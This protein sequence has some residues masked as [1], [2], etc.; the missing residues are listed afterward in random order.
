[1]ETF[2]LYGLIFILGLFLCLTLVSVLVYSRFI[3]IRYQ[4]EYFF[5]AVIIEIGITLLLFDF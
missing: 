1:M 3:T 5:L 4:S 2:V